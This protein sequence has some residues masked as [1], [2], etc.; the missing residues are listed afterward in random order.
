MTIMI[1]G[2]IPDSFWTGRGIL[3]SI[4]DEPGVIEPDGT[5]KWYWRGELHRTNGPAVVETNGNSRWYSR[6]V[7]HRADGPAVSYS[8]SK[9]DSWA[10]FGITIT[11]WEEFQHI[12]E[13]SDEKM[14][15]L[16]IKYGTTISGQ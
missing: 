12:T 6:G 9:R 8:D 7:L 5:K 15:L 16:K 4:N 13:S 14:L 3:H 11:S 1:N 2:R 10:V